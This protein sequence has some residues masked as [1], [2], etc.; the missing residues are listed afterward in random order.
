M[1]LSP[2]RSRPWLAA[3]AAALVLPIAAQAAETRYV[4]TN[5]VN[6]D[7]C[8]LNQPCRTL[9]RGVNRTPD[10]GELIVLNSGDYGASLTITRSITI[11]ADGVT[12]TLTNPGGIAIGNPDSVVTLRGLHLKGAGVSG[13]SG[14]LVQRAT[15]VHIERCTIEGFNS[16]GIYF[17]RDNAQLFITDSV[18]R[19]NNLSGLQV[20]ASN[21]TVT[22]DNSRFENNG[23]NGVMFVGNT[24]AT[25]TRSISS[26]NNING[27]TQN[28]GRMNITATTAAHNGANGYLAISNGEMTLEASVS[29]GNGGSGLRVA[30]GSSRARVSRSVVTDNNVGISNNGGNVQTFQ[31]NILLGNNTNLLN[32]GTVTTPAPF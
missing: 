12:A 16:R 1:I 15:A 32:S 7:D 29:R 13:V 6:N 28:A 9:Q 14:I 19:N 2:S 17:T 31:N 22:I 18:V 26:G 24:Q 4:A 8:S 20:D 27:I 23:S 30:D 25:I 21:V 10:G 11:S 3:C 5:G